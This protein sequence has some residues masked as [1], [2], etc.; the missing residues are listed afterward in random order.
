MTA[1][2]ERRRDTGFSWLP[3]MG[4]TIAVA[5]GRVWW[6]A[7]GAVA[8]SDL[9]PHMTV[10]SRTQ[11]PAWPAI[12]DFSTMRQPDAAAQCGGGALLPRPR[13]APAPP[14]CDLA[15]PRSLATRPN[16]GRGQTNPVW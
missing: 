11:E 16:Q 8:W 15:R 3:A 2:V 9:H 4:R 13:F 12:Y 14:L 7:I 10:G 6:A 5:C 1:R